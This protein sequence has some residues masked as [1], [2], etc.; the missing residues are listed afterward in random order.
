MWA[1][2]ALI[3]H[4]YPLGACG[5]P[6]H[7]D[8][9]SPAQPRLD[10]L[11]GE[12]DRLVDLGVTA[13]LLGPVFESTR[14]GYDTA[15]YFKVDRRLGATAT[16]QRF[17]QELSARGMRLILDAALNHVGRDFWAFRDVQRH[18]PA[19]EYAGWFHLDFTSCSPRGDQFSYDG[20]AGHDDLVKLNLDNP[21][22]REHLLS[23]VTHWMRTFDVAGLRLDAADVMSTDFLAVLA[24]HARNLRPDVWLVGEMVHGDYAR[25]ARPGLLDATTNYE[26]YKGLWS[27]HRD[28]NYF[29]IAHSLNRQFG[30]GGLY[31]E[32]P[33][34]SFADN[35]DVDRVASSVADPAQLY[36]LHGL[37]LTMPGV[38]AIYYGSEWGTR[39]RRTPHSDTAV[40]P[41]LDAIAHDEPGLPDAIR[42]LAGVRAA[43][44]ALRHGD[45]CQVDVASEQMS[46]TRT[47]ASQ[48][49]S[50]A[51]NNSSSWA[52]VRV[53]GLRDRF[54]H[55]ERAAV[56][57]LDGQVDVPPHWLRILT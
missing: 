16:L 48:Q 26:A 3:Y 10:A 49:V 8:F 7:N 21:A 6:H 47:C 27:A 22:V 51:V 20:W 44:P 37:L 28:H 15:D 40:R 55:L 11:V 54:D 31:R 36:P 32:L 46:F 1:R 56:E 53:R 35:H 30:P 23:A 41:R 45:Y 13:V 24:G 14:H 25:M 52:R 38:P 42:R 57:V 50:V 39:A 4:I 43:L 18:G 29:E 9:S 19:S 33:L 12:L 17:A 34:L 2:D 5:A